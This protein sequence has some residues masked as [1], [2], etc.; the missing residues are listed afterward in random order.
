MKTKLVSN[1]T[2]MD[3]LITELKATQI[4][5]DQ[6]KND[7]AKFQAEIRDLVKEQD[8]EKEKRK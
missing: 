2:E 7:K 1:K 3:K 8:H 5:D 4:V 6:P